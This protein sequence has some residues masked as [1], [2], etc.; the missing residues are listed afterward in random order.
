M[1]FFSP[2]IPF[3]ALL[4]SLL[5]AIPPQALG[6][7]GREAR[8]VF[9]ASVQGDVR[10]SNGQDHHPDLNTPWQEAL[11]GELVVEG[12]ALATGN[13]RAEIEFENGS[14]VYLAEN[15]LLLFKELRAPGDRVL[16]RMA[17]ATGRATF[18]MQPAI[19]EFFF[20]D[21]PTAQL[22]L[23][24]TEKFFVRLDA[25][26]DGTAITAEGQNGQP[27]VW[28][29]GRHLQLL[30]GKTVFF[31]DGEVIPPP[32]RSTQAEAL[33]TTPSPW[34][35]PDFQLPALAFPY[36]R[37]N[38][39]Y[40][41]PRD[42]Q[43]QAPSEWDAWVSSQ[44]ER[45]NTATAAALKAS[46]LPSPVPGLVDLYEQGRFFNCEPYGTCWEPTEPEA[47]EAN[48]QQFRATNQQS[49]AAAQANPVF[50]PQTIQWRQF[51]GGWCDPGRS[52]VV[53]RVAHS[54]EELRQLLA[55]KDSIEHTSPGFRRYAVVCDYGYWIRDRRH[56]VRVVNRGLPPGCLGGKCVVRGPRPVWVRVGNRIGFVP[57]HPND[58]K[59]KPPINLKEGMLIP[60]SKPGEGIARVALGTSQKVTVLD[61]AP[62]E[63]RS[64]PANQAL[65]VSAPE[66]RA[67]L[68]QEALPTR[69]PSLSARA[70]PP[71]TYDYESHH[72]LTPASAAAGGKSKGVP[73]GGIDS[74]GKIGSF[75]DGHSG[76]YA[77]SF[78]RSEAVTSY[79]GMYGSSYSGGERNSGYSSGSGSSGSH[80]S[81]SGSYAG[82]SS[83][84]S[85]SSSASSSSSS[86]GGSHGRP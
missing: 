81:A 17:L 83:H 10:I 7:K 85:S 37:T 35:M 59:G 71:I 20:I 36:N 49:P 12:S 86:G 64:E 62:R 29:D 61:K 48:P 73:V 50:Q 44:V 51:V 5:L 72:F 25:Y 40:P 66:I 82:G 8:A 24:E 11:G 18:S 68:L 32:A 63:V 30:K 14:T 6:S 70:V 19:G 58:V 78:A 1:K 38:E 39:L 74:H 52:V 60:P 4:S 76:A 56:Y 27:V 33:E 23:S 57:P 69:S 2:R 9:I 84:S 43:T 28:R 15:S 54:A 26:L 34:I 41:G 31:Q 3:F 42:E 21:T 53:T 65:H 67:H 13:G 80:S 45:R 77:Q 16:S 46:G 47:V 79:R 22:E 55:M 75:A